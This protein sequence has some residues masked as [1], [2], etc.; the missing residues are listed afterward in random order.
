MY[1]PSD[2]GKKG[3]LFGLPYSIQE[4]DLVILPVNLDVTV[5]YREGTSL[6]PQMILDES[7]QLDLSLPKIHNPWEM[8]MALDESLTS[9]VEHDAY[10]AKARKVIGQLE[11]GG[12]LK[13]NSEMILEINNYCE[14]V[15]KQIEMKCAEYLDKGKFVAVLG[16]D[17]SSPFG[18]IRALSGKTKFGIIQIDAHMDLRKAYEGFNYSHASIMYN[19][20]QLEGVESLTQVG[21]RDYCQEEEQ[22]IAQSKKQIHSF[23]DESLFAERMN[24]TAWSDQVKEIISTL[25]DSIYISF[26]IDGLDP[27]LC[28][29]TGTPVP[30]GLQIN[31]VFYLLDQ[32]VNTGKKII[33]FDLC[34]VGN[35]VWD[36]NVGARVLYRLA[37]CL[38][39]SRGKLSMK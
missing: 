17:H 9:E 10:R 30:G 13:E 33:G 6:A 32:I 15:H 39:V 35:G 29:K 16:G 24:G 28:P 1:N 7:S 23:F 3:S 8:K 2:V 27:S 18:L 5:S 37:T 4:S 21:I 20:L 22:Y 38:G 36:A 12:T 31:E 34:E 11:Q 25:P 26:D 19:A 14:V